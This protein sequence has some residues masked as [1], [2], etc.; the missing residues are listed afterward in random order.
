VLIIGLVCGIAVAWF[1][2]LEVEGPPLSVTIEP[3]IYDPNANI[4]IL[5][6]QAAFIIHVSNNRPSLVNLTVNVSAGN[7]IVQ[8][9]KM[10]V[11]PSE[12]RDLKISQQLTITGIWIVAATT[13][14]TG[15]SLSSY[16]FEV[17]VNKAEAD[18]AID[19][20]NNVQRN[21]LVAVAGVFIALASV[22]LSVVVPILHAPKKPKFNEEELKELKH[23]ILAEFQLNPPTPVWRTDIITGMSDEMVKALE[24]EREARKLGSTSEAARALLGEY[25][26]KRAPGR[27]RRSLE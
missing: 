6:E 16:S 12:K 23:R 14:E 9:Q 15:Q 4:G 2:W 18:V 17:E 8:S 3:R 21:W 25:F 22:V 19:Q 1:V 7:S 24:E 11:Q 27:T 20:W 26:K 13:N 10:I 5:N